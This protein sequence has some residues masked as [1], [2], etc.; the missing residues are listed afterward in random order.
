MRR[1][2]MPSQGM[3]LTPYFTL[4]CATTS[5]SSF[6]WPGTGR[7]ELK[8]SGTPN[9]GQ[10][11]KTPLGDE[12]AERDPMSGW[13]LGIEAARKVNARHLGTVRE[14]FF[15]QDEEVFLRDFH[16]VV[17]IQH[18]VDLVQGSA[19]ELPVQRWPRAGPSHSPQ[20][21]H[22]DLVEHSEDP[23]AATESLKIL[24]AFLQGNARG[25]LHLATALVCSSRHHA[26]LTG[27]QE[28]QPL[29][30]RLGAV[31]ETA[32]RQQ[33]C[34]LDVG[35]ASIA[36]ERRHDDVA[37]ALRHELLGRQASRQHLNAGAGLPVEL[38]PSARAAMH[39][40]DHLHLAGA[41]QKL[42]DEV[43][44]GP[45]RVTQRPQRFLLVLFLARRPRP[46]FCNYG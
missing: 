39:L 38:A 22:G 45:N 40:V 2:V 9:V 30:N 16:F 4:K 19:C 11:R 12:P 10:L 7:Y 33:A 25:L 8:S 18:V 29:A 13:C 32:Q 1:A 46:L 27:A 34:A 43:V 37:R 35:I 14:H 44:E 31:G 23:R 5:T 20:P 26:Y 3:R 42:V 15:Y 41:L 21:R 24:Q 6:S 28:K 17:Q 36:A